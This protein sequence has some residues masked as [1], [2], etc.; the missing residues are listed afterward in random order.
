MVILLSQVFGYS[1]EDTLN[2]SIFL[3]LGTGLAALLY[4]RNEVFRILTWKTPEDKAMF[5]KLFVMT[6][7][8]GGIG[9]GGQR[10]P[11]VLAAMR[12]TG[13]S[14]SRSSATP[15]CPSPPR[16]GRWK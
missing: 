13:P 8:T 9:T 12:C 6:M 14:T 10:T 2:T 15:C 4:F 5:M 3:H 11:A 7:L 1:V 16:R